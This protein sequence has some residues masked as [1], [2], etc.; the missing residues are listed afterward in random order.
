MLRAPEK[1]N[2]VLQ[3]DF[4]DYVTEDGENSRIGCV[5]EYLSRYNLVS[6]V[7]D[8]ETASDLI[9]VKPSRLSTR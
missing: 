6:E 2:E 8:T 1:L 7:L 4:T 5:T 3:G 9:A